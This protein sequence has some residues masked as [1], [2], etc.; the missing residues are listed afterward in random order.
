MPTG[1]TSITGATGSAAVTNAAVNAGYLCAVGDRRARRLHGGCVV[2]HGRHPDRCQLGA[3]LGPVGDLHDQQQRPDRPVDLGQDC[4]Q[5][6]R[7]DRGADRLDLGGRRSDP[8]H[9]R[10]RSRRGDQCGG[11]R[12]YLRVVRVRRAGR[13]FGRQLVLHRGHPDRCNGSCSRW[14]SRRPARSTTTTNRPRLTLVKTVTND[15]GGTALPTA[16]T[17]TGTGPTTITGATGSAA[18]TNASV[19]AGTYTLSES[20]GP[21]GYLPGAL[22]VYRRHVDGVE[23]RSGVG[24]FGDLHDQQ[25]R[26]GRPR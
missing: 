7:W 14:A 4:H 8:D 15:N 25:Q 17:L 20:T 11:Q 13:I 23:S 18:V 2:V 1:P 19:N 21:A 16:W 26:P 6:Q 3:R 10:H 22:V 5:R 24:C 9:R 12:R